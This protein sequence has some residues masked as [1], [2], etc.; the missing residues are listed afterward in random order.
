MREANKQ[1]MNNALRG[2]RAGA[3]KGVLL[4]VAV[5]VAVV[6]AML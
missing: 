6:V 5:A 4:V 1:R 2:R 3:E